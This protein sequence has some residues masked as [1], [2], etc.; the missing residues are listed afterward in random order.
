MRK[1]DLNWPAGTNDLDV[2]LGMIAAGGTLKGKGLGLF[3]HLMNAR[4]LLWPHRYRHRWTDLMYREFIKN[5][6][7]ILM[8]CASAQKT[9]H[10]VEF[11][12]INYFARPHKTMVILSSTTLEKLDIG[13]WAEL[14]TLWKQASELWPTLAG[15]LVEYKRAIATDDVEEGGRDFRCGCICRPCLPAGQ[16]VDTPSGPRPIE[17]IRIGDKV[18]NAVGVGTVIQ[19]HCSIGEKVVRVHLEDMG[20]FDCTPEHPVFTQRG[21]IKAVDLNTS[22]LVFSADETV[23]MLQRPIGSGLS[24]SKVLLPSVPGERNAKRMPLLWQNLPTVETPRRTFLQHGLRGKMGSRA[25]LRVPVRQAL[26]PLRQV[27]AESGSQS[28][29]LLRGMPATE[30]PFQMQAMREG[31]S[32][33]SPLVSESQIGFLQLVLCREMELASTGG[34][35]S[36]AE[37]QRHLGLGH[38]NEQIYPLQSQRTTE[39]IAHDA[40]PQRGHAGRKDEGRICYSGKVSD[41]R[42]QLPGWNVSD[43]CSVPSPEAGRGGGRSESHS[44]QGQSERF[45]TRKEIRGT[46]VAGVEIL[47]PRSDQRFSESLRG[48]PVYNLG[49]SNHPS[50]SVNGVV[51]HNCYRG[52]TYVGDSVLAGAKQD[53]IFFVADELSFMESSFSRSW[54]HLFSNPHVKIIGSGNPKGDPDDQLSI[55]GEPKDGWASIG[56]PKVTSC[57]DTRFMGGRCINLVGTDSPNFDVPEG[58]PEP[59][60]KL[61]GRSFAKRIEHD[62]GLDSYDYYKLV[63]GVMKLGMAVNRVITRQLCREHHAHDKA[64]WGI[65]KRKKLHSLDPSYGGKDACVSTLLEFG[66]DPDGKII[67]QIIRQHTHRFSLNIDKS[68]EDQ[69]AE[70]VY[71][72]LKLEGIEPSASGYDSVGK[73]TLGFAFARKFGSDSPVPIDSGAKPTER[74]VRQD[75]F[76]VDKGQKRHKKCSEHYSKFITEAWFSVRYVIEADQM[77]ELPEA[78]MMEGCAR[79]YEEVAGNKIEIE[80]KDDLKERTGKSPNLFDSLAVGVEMARRHGFKIG[81][82]GLDS[83]DPDQDP[84]AWMAE[85][86]KKQRELMDKKQLSYAT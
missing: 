7:S 69:I 71:D 41:S 57:W 83:D 58:T 59:Y 13:C 54:P 12:L 32:I 16:M 38:Q 35:C 5:D 72:M 10:S 55:S 1:Y 62:Q 73:G 47:E 82:L 45:D 36:D 86:A 39:K 24:Q 23:S 43:R 52:G 63:K 60:P 85:K 26:P 80:P 28:V 20:G 56:E 75:L 34:C 25:P 33:P 61:I 67:L 46:R 51:V 68:V 6:V 30:M 48:Y 84:F 64:Q 27:D 19:T 65:G 11:C 78:C 21:W 22:D 81:R 42:S 66:P 15:N 8:G 40:L 37:T 18:V 9:S 31:V 77:R 14:K 29:L 4:K 17:S 79:V 49:V 74:Q 50:F 3:E 44:H 76:I 53:Y 2:E 70:Q